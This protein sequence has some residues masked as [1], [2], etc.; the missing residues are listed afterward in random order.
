MLMAIVRCP[1][2]NV[3]LRELMSQLTLALDSARNVTDLLFM[4]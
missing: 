2:I 1:A 4:T 3:L